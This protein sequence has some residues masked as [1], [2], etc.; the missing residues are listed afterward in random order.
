MRDTLNAH[1]WR[2]DK[3]L[4]VR[5]TIDQQSSKRL[6]RAAA[7]ITRS[8]DALPLL[9]II[10]VLLI[11]GDAG[12]RMRAIIML[13]AD[14]IVFLTVQAV[15]FIIRRPRPEGD[16][17]GDYRRVDPHSFPSGHA[18]RGGAYAAAGLILGPGWLIL[19]LGIWGV[20]VSVS[21]VVVGVHYLS[22]TVAGF[23]TGFSIALVLAVVVL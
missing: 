5:L 2:A 11:F 22:D 9:L 16:W 17:G 7:L 19:L 20:C 15:K 13:A 4:S 14:T 23:L 6:H 10:A 21:R 18:A 3:A 1:L 8:G 12:W